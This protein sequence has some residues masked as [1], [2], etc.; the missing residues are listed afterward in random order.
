MAGILRDVVQRGTAVRAKTM[1]RDD[2]GGKTGTTNDAKDAW[3]AG[4]HPTNATV[5]WIGFDQP[6]TL[7]RREYGGVAALPVWMD[8]MQAQL[9]DTPRQW[10]SLNNT[11]KSK[12][13]KSRVIQMT[14]NG[15]ITTDDGVV[16]T[17][18][19]ADTD[20]KTQPINPAAEQ[21]E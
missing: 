9:K 10:V 21:R 12:K 19:K 16:T 17:D 3:F 4:F 18:N 5:V 15:I 11:S 2:I 6:S 13:Q 14:D 7:G 8:F 1:N 20:K